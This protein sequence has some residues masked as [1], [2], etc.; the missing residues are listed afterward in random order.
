MGT[1]RPSYQQRLFDDDQLCLSSHDEIVRWADLKAQFSLG[2][3][4]RS[5]DIDHLETQEGKCCKWGREVVEC[6]ELFDKYSGPTPSTLL[7]S[8]A[9][10]IAGALPSPPAILASKPRWECLVK[11]PRGGMVGAID[12]C[13]TIRVFQPVL[14]VRTES[15]PYRQ[16]PLFRTIFDDLMGS[17]TSGAITEDSFATVGSPGWHPSTAIEIEPYRTVARHAGKYVGLREAEWTQTNWATEEFNIFIEAKTEVR[18]AGELIRQMNLYRAHLSAKNA[19]YLVVAPRNRIPH[20]LPEILSEQGL[21]F[22]A[23]DS[24]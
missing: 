13:F 18:A 11:G 17:N 21:H 10:K 5:L 20:N 7:T 14:W 6:D 24:N 15:V 9:R 2:T 23:H 1:V 16:L 8:I 3:I 19:K 22:L 4:L 12:L